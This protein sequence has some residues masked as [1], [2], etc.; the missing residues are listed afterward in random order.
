VVQA[1]GFRSFS[2]YLS[3]LREFD[4]I[5]L[6]DELVE[7]L[8]T[9]ET[10]FNRDSHPFEEFRRRILPDLA[11]D[12]C[13][14]RKTSYAKPLVRLWSAGC[15]TGQEAYSLAMSVIDFLSANPLLELMPEQFPI[16]ATDVSASSL[17]VARDGR[18]SEREIERGL[19]LEARRRHFEQQGDIWIANERLRRMIDFRRLNFLDGVSNLGSFE[20][21]LCRNVMIYFDAPTRQ[22]LCDQLCERLTPGGI[23]ILG[24]AESLY[25]LETLLQSEQLGS[26]VVYRKG[27]QT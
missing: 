8:A 10:S 12:L 14:R 17:N 9:G 2:E 16:L 15:S 1:H 25:G 4:A 18:Y 24:A 13:R 26:T 27:P 22:R 6:R 5:L 19:S 23:L 3:R 20:V 11:V 21:I 7:A